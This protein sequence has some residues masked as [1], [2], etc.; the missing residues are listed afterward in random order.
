MLGNL[1]IE[2]IEKRAGVKFPDELVEYMKPRWQQKAENV[3][4]G[5]WHCFDLPFNLVCGDME[6]AT[7]IHNHLKAF[8]RDFKEPLQISLTK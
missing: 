1:T 7:E 3:G 6:T 5:K 4:I 2:Q 8:S